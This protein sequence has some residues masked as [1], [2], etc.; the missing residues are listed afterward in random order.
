MGQL[1]LP[2][3]PGIDLAREHQ[4]ICYLVL[5]AKYIVTEVRCSTG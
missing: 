1:C 4:A 5:L 3:C 2:I